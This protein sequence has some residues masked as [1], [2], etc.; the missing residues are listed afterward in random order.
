[1]LSQQLAQQRAE[2]QE[3]PPPSDP[4]P[5]PRGSLLDAAIDQLLKDQPSEDDAN[6][7]FKSRE[8]SDLTRLLHV[9]VECNDGDTLVIVNFPPGYSSC[10]REEVGQFLALSR[11]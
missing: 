5:A 3:L 9:H 11:L 8:K 7:V 1:M 10:S 2:S 4:T 6:Y